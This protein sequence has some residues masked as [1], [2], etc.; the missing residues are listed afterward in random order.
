[1]GKY[2]SFSRSCLYYLYNR[3]LSQLYLNLPYRITK[4]TVRPYR[5]HCISKSVPRLFVLYHR[6]ITR[7]L[8]FKLRYYYYK[9][10]SNLLIY[11]HVI[12]S[13][14]CSSTCAILCT[15]QK[16][17][18]RD[19]CHIAGCSGLSSTFFNRV[20]TNDKLPLQNL[21]DLTNLGGRKNTSSGGKVGGQVVV[22]E[23]KRV[24]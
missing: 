19:Q 15:I 12:V 16:S 6:S 22:T 5:T 1:M 21:A 24:V 20:Q 17:T 14:P 23:K 8:W 11:P 2:R 10:K 18:C 3:L 4:P 9:G 7:L 13:P